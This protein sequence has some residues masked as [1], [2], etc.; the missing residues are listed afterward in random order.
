[1]NKLRMIAAFVLAPLMTPVVLL[2]CDLFNRTS[3]PKLAPFYFALYGPFAY[4]ATIIFGIPALLLFRWCNWTNIFLF[5]AGGAL[6]GLL[7]FTLIMESF[8][9][10]RSFYRFMV[11]AVAGALS[12]ATFRLLLLGFGNAS[13]RVPVRGET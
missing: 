2:A 8:G 6:I 4:A 12:A 1:M 9:I 3:S 11:C 7:L 10:E 13:Y 5:L